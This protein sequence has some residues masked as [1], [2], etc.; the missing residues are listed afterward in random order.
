LGLAYSR[1]DELQEQFVK[2]TNEVIKRGFKRFGSKAIFER[3]RWETAVPDVRG[4]P[5]FKLSNNFHAFY[6]R[7][8]I[9]EH[10]EHTGLFALH[11]QPSKNKPPLKGPDP[12]W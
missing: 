9:A 7:K 8:F 5:S 6:A 3:I 2:F 4:R 11:D 10:P 1:H 12:L